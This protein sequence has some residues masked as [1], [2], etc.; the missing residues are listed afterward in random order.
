MLDYVVYLLAQQ[1]MAHLASE[2]LPDAPVQPETT[3]P[4]LRSLRRSI[5]LALYRLADAVAPVPERR[6]QATSHRG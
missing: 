1:R 5:G 6:E 3:R 2:A 4:E